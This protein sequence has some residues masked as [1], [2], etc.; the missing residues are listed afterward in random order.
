M[1]TALSGCCLWPADGAI[2]VSDSRLTHDEARRISKLI[3]HFPELVELQRE[4]KGA[5]RS[6]AKF[7]SYMSEILKPTPHHL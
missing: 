4:R 6:R 2:A 5:G 3:S 7:F 1:A